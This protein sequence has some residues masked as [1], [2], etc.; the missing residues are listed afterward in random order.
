MLGIRASAIGKYLL[1]REFTPS[2]K[3]HTPSR[4]KGVLGRIWAK[5]K[6]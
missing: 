5:N 6:Q 3:S 2:D 4:N 1:G